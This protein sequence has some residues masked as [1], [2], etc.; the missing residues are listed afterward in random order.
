MQKMPR[1]QEILQPAPSKKK[2][3]RCFREPDELA[4][5]LLP[6]KGRWAMFALDHMKESEMNWD[7][8]E[9]IEDR[10]SDW[11][12]DESLHPSNDAPGHQQPA[13]PKS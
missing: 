8:I 9:G 3:S 5:A 13:R 1:G 7:R 12:P 4:R 11:S 6:K 2:I 10:Y